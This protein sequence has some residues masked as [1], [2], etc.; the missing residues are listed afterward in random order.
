MLL[1]DAADD[2]SVPLQR[3]ISARLSVN[4]VDNV[5]VV[6]N[7]VT[8]SLA[9]L[10]DADALTCRQAGAT[11]LLPPPPLAV[12]A[13]TLFSVPSRLASRAFRDLQPISAKKGDEE[14]ILSRRNETK[15]K[16]CSVCRLCLRAHS[17]AELESRKR[18]MDPSDVVVVVQ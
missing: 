16:R 11:A 3:V 5:V 18:K 15:R 2:D 6:D 4:T 7:F 14:E 9:Q 8:T 10:G 12:G 13:L 1:H 17:A